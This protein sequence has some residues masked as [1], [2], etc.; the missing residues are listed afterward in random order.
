MP[1]G[2]S[3]PGPNVRLSSAADKRAELFCAIGSGAM[4]NSCDLRILAVID[5]SQRAPFMSPV[6]H[7]ADGITTLPAGSD[8]TVVSGAT[9]RLQDAGEA[10]QESF[11]VLL[12]AAICVVKRAPGGSPPPMRLKR[13]VGATPECGSNRSCFCRTVAKSSRPFR[14]STGFVATAILTGRPWTLASEV[15]GRDQ[16]T[17]TVSLSTGIRMTKPL[18]QFRSFR[19]RTACQ[20]EDR[21]R[22]DLNRRKRPSPPSDSGSTS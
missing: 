13:T 7:H 10:V 17:R 11:C 2:C 4:V 22:C 5:V 12:A 6:M 19:G 14:K 1:M 15:F 9:V 20:S 18:R 16:C 3:S 21:C 8:Q